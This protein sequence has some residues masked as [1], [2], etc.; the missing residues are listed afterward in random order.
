MELVYISEK[1]TD[2]LRENGDSRVSFNR[3]NDYCR[4]YVGAVFIVNARLFFAPLT[5]SNKGKKLIDSPKKENLTFFP[6]DDCRLG[7]LNLNN[8]IPV[9][10]GVYKAVDC[11]ISPKDSQK[12]RARKTRLVAQQE[13]L[14]TYEKQIRRKA[15]ILYNL[16]SSGELYKNYDAITC[17]F[18]KLE[19]IA[20]KFKK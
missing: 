3:E 7:G 2:F 12:A 6:I 17:D 1:Y 15:R 10:D 19:K 9:I 8:M 5:S 16:K 14:K 4:P 11:E 13:F 20:G 18:G